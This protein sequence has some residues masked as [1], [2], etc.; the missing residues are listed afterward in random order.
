M[1]E[2]RRGPRERQRCKENHIKLDFITNMFVHFF[3]FNSF[4]IE[5]GNVDLLVCEM[6]V[7]SITSSSQLSVLAYRST[8]PT[9]QDPLAH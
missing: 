6:Q 1:L 7:S 2:K 3:F 4:V 9:G 5:P 8:R